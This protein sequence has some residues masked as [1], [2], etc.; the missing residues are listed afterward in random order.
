MAASIAVIHGVGLR[1]QREVDHGL[2]EDDPALGHADQ[3]HRLGRGDGGLQRG[4]VG[5]A[6]VLAGEDTIRRAMNRGS[7]PASI[8]RAR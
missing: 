3:L 4:R 1:R 2:G 5:H 8:I 6:D 7:S